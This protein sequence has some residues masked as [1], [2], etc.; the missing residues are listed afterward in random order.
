[1]QRREDAERAWHMVAAMEYPGRGIVVGATEDNTAFIQVYWIMGRSANSRNRIFEQ[2]GTSLKTRAFD[3]SK[4]EDPSL[5]LYYPMRELGRYHIVSN[6]DQT[7]TIYDFLSRGKSFEEALATRR[8]EPDAPNYTPRISGLID[9]ETG[10][11][12]LSILKTLDNDPAFGVRHCFQYDTPVPGYG[13]FIHTYRS[14]G[15]PLP[16]FQGEPPLLRLP[17]GVD[18]IAR[19]FWAILNPDNRI[20]LCVKSIDRTSGAVTF[21]ILN[22][23]A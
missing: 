3:P 11:I 1:M 17:G 4:V 23:Y 8:F 15:T 14:N 7:D 18:D 10:R 12:S 20:S 13:F 22:K 2:E 21:S 16:S 9:R 5:I 19:E 6:G